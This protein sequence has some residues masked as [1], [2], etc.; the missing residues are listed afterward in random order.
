MPI[1][2]FQCDACNRTFEEL[3]R[4]PRD[5]SGIRCPECGGDK[6]GR[7]ISVFS[8]GTSAGRSTPST[9][10]PTG[11][12]GRCGDPAGPCALD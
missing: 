11:G 6:I 4:S 7:Q 12:C 9:P 10:L 8:A 1:H 5:E 3:V 2:E